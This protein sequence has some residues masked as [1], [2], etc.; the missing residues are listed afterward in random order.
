[1]SRSGADAGG[2][3]PI[4]AIRCGKR[5]AW[6]VHG[7]GLSRRIAG[8]PTPAERPPALWTIEEAG[9]PEPSRPRSAGRLETI[10]T[11]KQTFPTAKKFPLARSTATWRC[12]HAV[13]RPCAA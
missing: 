13:P 11:R 5:L 8:G 7:A 2:A 9:A 3:T 10:Q 4:T 12:P 1:M 6:P